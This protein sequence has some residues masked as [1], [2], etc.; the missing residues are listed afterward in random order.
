MIKGLYTSVAGLQAAENRQQT[1][2]ASL[3]NVNTPGYKAD[4]VTTESFE[5]VFNAL[6]STPG[7][8]GTGAVTSGDKLDLSQGGFQQTGAPLDLALDGDG[9]FVLD[10]PNGQLFTR[11]GRFMRDA[12]GT[13]RTPDGNPVE[14]VNG[15]PITVTGVNVQVGPDGTVLSDNVP[16]GRIKLVTL[17]PA[18]LTRAGTATFSSSGQPG[19]SNAKVVSGVL[20]GSN[21][22]VSSVM[23]AM[24]ILLRAFEAGNSAIQLQNQTLN[25]TVNQVGATPGA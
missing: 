21:V 19:Q 2:A 20:E 9:F 17:D 23:T 16:V 11:A 13:L 8:P 1:L 24:T 6:F 12:G 14:G 7:M 18:T 3:A 15:Q 4:D 22:D 25:A 5:K 10:G